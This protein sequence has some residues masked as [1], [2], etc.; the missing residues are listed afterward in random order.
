LTNKLYQNVANDFLGYIKKEKLLEKLAILWVT[1][2]VTHALQER[3]LFDLHIG[4]TTSYSTLK[5]TAVMM[6]AA[7]LAFGM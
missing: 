3:L 6:T 7:R 5:M 2:W 4:R 1:S